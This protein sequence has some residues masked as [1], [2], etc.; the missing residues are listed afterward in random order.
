MRPPA[1]PIDVR[2]SRVW[3]DAAAGVVCLKVADGTHYDRG[4]AEDVMRA[5]DQVSAGTAHPLLIDVDGYGNADSGAR[6]IW[7]APN[8]R[9]RVTSMA[10]VVRS[11]V[12]RVIATFFI[13]VTRPTIPCAVFTTLDEALRWSRSP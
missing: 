6:Q 2:T 10:I 8:M 3:L 12:V 9:E 7:A 11:P 13:R 1:S 5:I 4:Y